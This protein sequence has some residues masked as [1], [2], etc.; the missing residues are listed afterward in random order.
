MIPVQ[1]SIN[2]ID[3]IEG[4]EVEFSIGDPR[5]VMRTQ[6]D[7][8]SNRELAV[9]RE[10]ST[11][12]ADA[13]KEA[14][15]SRP[16]EVRLPS[17]MDP[18]FRVR[19][20]GA[21]MSTETMK[22][23]YTKFGS[24]TKRGSNDFN[25][26]LGYGSKAAIAY[27]NNFT[28]TSI[29]NGIKTVG[30]IIR[31]DDWS[32]VMKIVRVSKTDEPSGTEVEV[33]VHNWQEFTTKALDFYKFWLP[34]TVLVNGKE[35]AT[36][37]GK[38][39]VDGLYLCNEWNTSY[40]VMG[41]VPYRIA[42][43]SALFRESKMREVNFIAYVD[44]GDVEFTP[45]RED[46]KYTDHTKREL[47]R[48]VDNFQNKIIDKAM[49]EIDNAA[50]HADAYL[51][52]RGWSD[53]LGK[54]MF[55]SLTYKGDKF[56]EMFAIRGSVYNMQ[57]NYR[58]SVQHQQR[59]S[60]AEATKTLFVTGFDIN[61]TA[62]HK[63]MVKEYVKQ[64]GLDL[65]RVFFMA[66]DFSSVDCVWI[67]ET[68][69]VAWE[70]IK[71]ALPKPV[72]QQVV[73]GASGRPVGAFDYVDNGGKHVGNIPD[74]KDI[75]LWTGKRGVNIHNVQETMKCLAP[76]KEWAVILMPM[77]RLDKFRRENPK[78]QRLMDYARSKIVA[79]GASLLSDDDKRYLSL[80]HTDRM[81]LDKMDP[82]LLD[83]PELASMAR[84]VKS[85]AKTETMKAYNDNIRLASLVGLYY[86]V[87]QYNPVG[88]SE[89]VTKRY[90]LLADMRGWNNHHEHL[91]IYLNAAY[92]AESEA[93]NG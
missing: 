36:F 62:K 2:Q 57:Y 4:D 91:H 21:G 84:L 29:H 19:D 24:S 79:D 51:L 90:P 49:D 39:I 66:G 65:T 70:D 3:T 38:K 7:L 89:W 28:V 16:I 56:N 23:I 32:I 35:P 73:R 52:W 13:N 9:T 53:L 76:G 5:W 34:G 31:R 64:K 17:M 14:G 87:K 92:A 27:T 83:D 10:Y 74:D 1:S 11:N 88:E 54:A 42:N 26:M 46:L 71:A 37:I 6:A 77:N 41:N 20:F 33:P 78:V 60:V 86:T 68:N 47:Q 59:Y 22:T 43:P 30:M 82:D 80:D 69:F 45:S 48:V 63:R 55:D 58:N 44:N 12:A 40:V 50:S 8:Y 18:F 61:I 93:K 81:W 72:R 75:I 67:D 85:H 15:A 25:G